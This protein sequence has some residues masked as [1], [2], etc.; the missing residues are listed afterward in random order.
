MCASLV[1]LSK[2]LTS[3]LLPFYVSGTVSCSL[4]LSH[5]RDFVKAPGN[6]A[7]AVAVCESGHQQFSAR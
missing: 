1:G 3:C 7:A 5:D 6:D 4:S 2:G